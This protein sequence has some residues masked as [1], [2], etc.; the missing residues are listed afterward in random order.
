MV[1]IALRALD[2]APVETS[3]TLAA[4]DPLLQGIEPVLVQPV[5]MS[6]RLSAAGPGRYYWRGRLTSQ[7]RGACRRCLADVTV[8][9]GV[10]VEALFTE[11]PDAADPSVYVIP[12][13]TTVLDLSEAVREE[14]LLGIPEYV[15]CRDDCAGLCPRCG[16]DWNQG[17]CS[18]PGL[19]DSRWAG[20][21][22]LKGKLQ[23]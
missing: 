19:T 1:R 20:L 12:P 14:L 21:E 17:P 11:E 4:D 5:M 15:L 2:R 6:G 7:V 22:A 18:C 10:S 13:N 3:G 16:Q 8:P 23:E 9:V